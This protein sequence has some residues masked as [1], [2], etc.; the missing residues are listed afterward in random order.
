[1]NTDR[2]RRLQGAGFGSAL[3]AEGLLLALVPKCPLCVAAM[4]SFWGLGAGVAGALAPWLRPVALLSAALCA[5]ALAVVLRRRAGAP[6]ET[7][8]R[9]C[10]CSERDSSSSGFRL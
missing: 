2:R 10:C 9:A 7:G 1:M 6:V 3:L 8:A 4:L 5:L